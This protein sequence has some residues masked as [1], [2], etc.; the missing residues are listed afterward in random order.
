MKYKINDIAKVTVTG[1]EPYGAFVSFD[2][3]TKGLLHISEISY[4]YVED[5]HDYVNNHET[6][7]VK[8]IDVLNDGRVRVSLKALKPKNSRKKRH[9]NHR[10]TQFDLGFSTLESQLKI[11]IEQLEEEYENKI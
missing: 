3:G 11:W 2:D 1:L 10:L 9:L 4:D 5:I 8:I 6:L 7:E